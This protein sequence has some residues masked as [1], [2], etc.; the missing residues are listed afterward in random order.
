ME[1]FHHHVRQ[2]PDFLQHDL[3]EQVGNTAGLSHAQIVTR[4]RTSAERLVHNRYHE[5]S[6]QDINDARMYLGHLPYTKESI[7]SYLNFRRQGITGIG[8]SEGMNNAHFILESNRF[9]TTFVNH[10][11]PVEARLTENERLIAQRQAEEAARQHAQRLAEEA[12]RHM[13]QQQAEEAARELARRQAE[14]ALLRAQQEVEEAARR[15]AQKKAAEETARASAIRPTSSL[16]RV[17][18]PQAASEVSAAVMVLKNSI[19][20]ALVVF[21]NSIAPHTNLTED[22]HFQALLELDETA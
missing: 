22:S 4:Y 8:F 7:E 5:L 21:A 20:Q 15:L 17:L 11:V 19:D 1:E 2:L 13:A 3:A 10:I 14:E 6:A 12:A 16:E 18:G 9:L